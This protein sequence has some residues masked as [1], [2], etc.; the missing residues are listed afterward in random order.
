HQEAM[1]ALL[2]SS[3]T[4][5]PVAACTTKGSD[6]PGNKGDLGDYTMVQP[7]ARAHAAVIA[8]AFACDRARCATLRILDDYP[9]FYTDAP[10]VKASGAEALYGAT[11][12]YH[13]NLVHDYWGAQGSNLTTL[14]KGYT[15]GLRW[16]ATHFA[17]VLDE[18]SKVIDPL[19]PSGG[20]MQDNTV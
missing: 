7:V 14:R 5:K 9:N 11:Y 4:P 10:E 13:E 6:V 2:R 18:F 1:K 8:Q 16:A 12:R 19:D 17:A 20:T 15:A 3:S